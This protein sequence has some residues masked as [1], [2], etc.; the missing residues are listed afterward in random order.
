MHSTHITYVLTKLFIVFNSTAAATE[1]HRPLTAFPLA[2]VFAQAVAYSFL[3][4]STVIQKKKK[5]N[6]GLK[7]HL[8]HIGQLRC[9]K[10]PP[11]HNTLSSPETMRRYKKQ[12]IIN[13]FII[14]NNHPH[15]SGGA[16]ACKFVFIIDTFFYYNVVLLLSS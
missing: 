15:S 12:I 2:I 9:Q 10:R 14:N 5:N 13:L 11:C 7:R 3:N 8:G 1:F 16:A 4:L 6:M